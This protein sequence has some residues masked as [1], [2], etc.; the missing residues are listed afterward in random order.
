MEFATSKE[1]GFAIN[2]SVEIR[3]E[4]FHTN[5]ERMYATP[6][7]NNAN[8]DYGITFS[9]SVCPD[10]VNKKT[11]GWLIVQPDI[12]E[13]KGFVSLHNAVS[14]MIVSI[15]DTDGHSR[16]PK[17]FHIDY[18]TE[19]L[20]NEQL[21]YAKYLERSFIL[22]RADE[23]L[24]EDVLTLRC[25]ISLTCSGVSPS[26]PPESFREWPFRAFF[27]SIPRRVC[28]ENGAETADPS[29][30]FTVFDFT[31]RVITSSEFHK[32]IMEFG[33]TLS[34]DT[35]FSSESKEG[36]TEHV[37]T[38]DARPDRFLLSLDE[39]QDSV[40]A[41]FLKASSLIRQCVEVPLKGQQENRI[42]LPNVDGE[43]FKIVL[44]FLA[45]GTLPN[46]EFGALVNVYKF[47]HLY[48]MEELLRRCAEYLTKYL[49][50]ETYL[51]KDLSDFEEL[52]RIAN[53]YSDKYLSELLES[54]RREYEN[55][56][57]DLRPLRM[58]DSAYSHCYI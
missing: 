37:W 40:G 30:T 33:C 54:R 35:L 52:E 7:E 2:T 3:I 19:I 9:V 32:L 20:Q 6:I 10:G 8:Q 46:F 29:G 24:P 58:D 42:E 53:L 17:S 13:N 51:E 23:F 28:F 57:R 50:T 47:A 11:E 5:K 56:E 45:S 43:T 34:Y 39:R 36:I 38:F 55:L 31:S 12:E 48:E 26:C 44:F 21:S 1:E 15:I 16:L 41:R 49:E 18:D 27:R 4:N 14:S 25:D 22:S